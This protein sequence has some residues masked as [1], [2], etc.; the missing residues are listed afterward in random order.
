MHLTY[1]VDDDSRLPAARAI[2]E[3]AMARH[4]PG[5]QY[6]VVIQSEPVRT[7]QVKVGD[8]FAIPLAEG[9]YALGVCRFVFQ[10][11]KGFTACRILDS[12]V[13]EPK[14]VGALPATAA[15]DPLFVWDHSIA[16]GKWPIIGSTAVEPAPLMYRSAGGIYNG[17]EYLR[18]T[19]YTEDVP[20]LYL[21][22]PV[23]VENQ[24]REY[25]S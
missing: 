7:F 20:D 5:F 16:D 19:D 13:P 17:D 14:L 15:F 2:I 1:R 24:L 21:P 6:E 22:G 9:H 3:A 11:Y 25:F 18:P 12:L 10:R 4:M 23:A 8:I